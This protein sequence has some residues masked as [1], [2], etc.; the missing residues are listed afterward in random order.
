MDQAEDKVNSEMYR[1]DFH[2]QLVAANSHLPDIQQIWLQ[3]VRPELLLSYWCAEHNTCWIYI[4]QNKRLNITG[5]YLILSNDET[6]LQ[7]CI[8][9]SHGFGNNPSRM[10]AAKP[11]TSFQVSSFCQLDAT[12]NVPTSLR[13]FKKCKFY[14]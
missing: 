9:K 4:E 1:A 14:E 10:D 6:T 7:Q 3:G 2:K 11:T 5:K 13:W 8:T 12:T